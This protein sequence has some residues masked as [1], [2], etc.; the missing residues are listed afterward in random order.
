MA[1]LK[2]VIRQS[3]GEQFEV[4]VPDS[5]S[6]LDLKQACVEGAKLEAENQRLI[7]KGNPLFEPLIFLFRP[8]LKRREHRSLLWHPRW[9]DR[10]FGQGKDRCQLFPR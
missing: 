8:Y 9:H 7:F 5:A 6:V 3:N 2:L 10:T 1:E 4:T